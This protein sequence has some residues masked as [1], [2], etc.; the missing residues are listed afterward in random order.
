[1][2]AAPAR[3][4][5]FAPLAS[6]RIARLRR[7]PAPPVFL[8]AAWALLLLAWAA[9]NPPFAAPDEPAHYLRAV[10]VG[11]GHLGPDV[12]VDVP[13]RLWARWRDPLGTTCNH[14]RQHLSA[15]CIADVDP[16]ADA[17][18]VTTAA[19]TYPP[20]SYVLPGLALR[21]ADDP[22]TATRIARLVF[23]AVSLGFLLLAVALLA[24]ADAPRLSTL[25][26]L[27]AVSPMVVFVGA[28]VNSSALEITAGIAFFAGLLR[29]SRGDPAPAWTWAATAV[30]GVALA[31]SRTTGAVWLVL[32][33]LVIVLLLG[34]RR[35]LELVRG[36]WR[37]AL[38]TG[39][40]FLAAVMANRLWEQLHG[41]ELTQRGAAST[42]FVEQV[43]PALAQV[44]RVFNEEVGVFG[45]L[46][47][48]MPGLAY[49]AWQAMVAGVVVLA[50]LVGGRRERC[51]IV[52]TGTLSIA[53]VVFL[54]A[55]L[56]AA[57]GMDVQGRHVLPF[58]VVVPLLAGE[59]VYRNRAK[60]RL[61]D[62]G[63]LLPLFALAVGT[64]HVLGWYAN[65]RRQSVGLD[66]PLSIL[67]RPEWS[68]PLGWAPWLAVAGLGG[69]LMVLSGIAARTRAQRSS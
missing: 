10:A 67:A 46:D 19:G 18:P 28:S 60:L 58:A 35:T 30:A 51:A 21:A 27:L 36:A 52:I 42:S 7:L 13:A 69:V 54:S 63:G 62:V 24:S 37:R 20:V 47:T 17:T 61:A 64:I 38:A 1:M 2:T 31:L 59:L 50:F 68:P 23:A 44:P 41:T 45:W 66:G 53:V 39:A 65:A 43:R 6:V 15:A 29:L 33:V 8:G 55:S 56:V 5:R 26:L 40:A 48:V 3:T 14:G 11:H 32:D 4:A 49:P 22:F 57:T 25:G 12:E 16:I 34:P 9:A